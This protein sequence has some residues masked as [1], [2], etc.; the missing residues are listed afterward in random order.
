[1]ALRISRLALASVVACLGLMSTPSFA[2][3]TPEE[4]AAAAGIIQAGDEIS[5]RCFTHEK[6]H[7]E[8]RGVVL[9]DGTMALP[10][11]GVVPLA[12]RGVQM[13]REELRGR[14][15]EIYPRCTVNISVWH[16]QP[17]EPEEEGRPLTQRGPEVKLPLTVAPSEETRQLP[18]RAGD[19]LAV[20]CFTGQD[21][22]VNQQV[23][24]SHRGTISLPKV[25]ELYVAALRPE[26][27]EGALLANY[28]PLY[29]GCSVD[30]QHVGKALPTVAPPTGERVEPTVE[31]TAAVRFASL[32]RFGLDVFTRPERA[33]GPE[34]TT[35]GPPEEA[36][37]PPVTQA[38]TPNYVLGPGDE[39]KVRVWT[40]AIE[41]INTSAVID[42]DGKIYLELV[43]EV[44]V[45]GQRL[46][47]VREE[48]TRRYARFF[49]RAEVSVELA[50][51]RV[52][53]VRVTG[54]ARRPGKQRLT[55]AAT[56]FSALYAAGGPSEVGALRGIRLLRSGQE[57]MVIDLYD[58]L[59]EGDETGDLPLEPDDTIFIPP[60]QAMVGLTG[61]VR[62]PG[63]YEL[64]GP[65][66]LSEALK[67]AAGLAP[68]AY[69][70]NVQVWRVA[71]QSQRRVLNTNVQG[72]GPDA[73]DLPLQDGDLIAALPVLEDPD[74]VVELSGAVRRP[75]SY[76]VF[77]G[78]TV[79]DLI[80]QAQGLEQTAH[81]ETAALWRLNDELDYELT[82]FDL[83]AAMRGD[84]THNLRLQA[85]DR[86]IVLSEET[87]EPPME[88]EVRG[89]V[90]YPSILTWTRGMRVSDLLLQGGG[91]AEDAYLERASLQRVG[92]NQR[93]EH[94]SVNLAEA[95]ARDE[96]ADMVLE[97]GDILT[98]FARSEVVAPSE[99]RVSG[100]VQKPETYPRI[101]RMRASD[102]ILAAGGLAPEAGDEIEY[103]PGG[104][105]GEVAPQYLRLRRV[106]GGFEV[107]PDVLLADDDHI[108]VLGAG[109]L[110]AKPPTVQIKGRVT[111]PGPYAL[112]ATVEQPDTVWKLIERAEGL[113]ADAN[114]N[115]IVLYRLREALIA[116]E[117][118]EDLQQLIDAFNRELREQMLMSE[119][120]RSAA[121]GEQIT[122]GL[123]NVFSS[124][125]STMLIVP[126]ERLSAQ[127]WVRAVPIDGELLTST[128]GAEG[129]FPLEEGDVVVVPPMPTTVTVLGSVVRRGA[130][131]YVEGQPV[132]QYLQY[133]GGATD[134]AWLD[135]LVIVRAN[136]RVEARALDAEVKPGD[137][138]LVPSTYMFRTIDSPT[139][140]ER[141]LNILGTFVTGYL[142]F[143]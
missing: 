95:L 82:N 139:T 10:Q 125:R 91:P 141:V 98:V 124:E 8:V 117:Q 60:A 34:P 4:E 109:D 44:T 13:V 11:L 103:T 39:L 130:V 15:Q 108:A 115:G 18:V 106:G 2:Q 76:E 7:V 118:D 25:P 88:V 14:Y 104:A 31:V 93:R 107:E 122:Q 6:R 128:D 55:G 47:R 36:S 86:V 78:M 80:D 116:D 102:A 3:P 5:V 9:P 112:R 72:E 66:S 105:R 52:I 70:H 120:Q 49:D 22:H 65:T 50:R 30:V 85:R 46:S 81:T 135:R 79:R 48:L 67:M 53:E 134:G 69:A 110:I 43:N 138:I 17:E 68:T 131:P 62:R 32:P 29:P 35:T 77:D 37:Q 27:V 58:Y 87:V 132:R 45:S 74:N 97:R 142:L 54:D 137:V 20:R 94:L 101:E 12:G 119:E 23:S 40:G 123:L 59:L 143:K 100:F 38:V 127:A 63:R 28:R 92:G 129:D 113:L 41:H 73:A 75:A 111:R 140:F 71:E 24:V 96:N 57:P 19:E 21:V 26:Q 16:P 114:P 42:A 126:P 121:L 89:A 33:E 1:V 84:A 99:I 90:R 136:G 61:E 83:A 133:A 51:T 56:V 64:D